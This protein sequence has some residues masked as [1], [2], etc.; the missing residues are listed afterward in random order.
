V[1]TKVLQINLI[2]TERNQQELLKNKD[3]SSEIEGE[4]NFV[5]D[6]YFKLHKNNDNEERNSSFPFLE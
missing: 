1:I 6:S 4:I 2:K 5:F 3:N